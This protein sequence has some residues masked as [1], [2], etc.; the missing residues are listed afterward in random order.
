ML[1][2]K[3]TAVIS[4]VKKQSGWRKSRNAGDHPGSKNKPK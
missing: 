2:E 3:A 4:V 1:M